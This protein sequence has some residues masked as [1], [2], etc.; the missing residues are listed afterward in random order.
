VRE[1]TVKKW[2]K[3]KYIAYFQSFSGTYASAEY[4][5]KTYNDALAIDDVVGLSVST[6][7]DCI[8]DEVLDVLGEM[9]QR[10]YLWVE[11]GLQ[12]VHD[13]TLRWLNRGHDYACFIEAL[14]KLRAVI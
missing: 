12:S 3:A 13:S 14:D 1:R 6:R 8:N 7:P 10:T 5:R 2:P 4:L 9:N 11:L